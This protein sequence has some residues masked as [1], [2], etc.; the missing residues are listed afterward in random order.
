VLWKRRKPGEPSW[1]RPPASRWRAVRAGTSS[2]RT[3]VEA[4]RRTFDIHGGASIWCFPHH[5]KNSRK[6]ACA[7][8]ADRMANIWMHNG[9]AAVEGDK[10]SKSEGILSPS[11]VAG[12]W[13][14]EVLRLSMLK[15]HYRSPI[16]WT[17]KGMEES[18]K[19]STTGTGR[20][21]RQGETPR[22]PSSRHCPTTSIRAN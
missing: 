18:A 22:M 10:M 20:C 15:T 5:E 2:A 12:R 7:F 8:H 19:R 9:F 13:P 1:R 14:G 3:G 16:D 4:P 17:L 11:G 6:S 21:G